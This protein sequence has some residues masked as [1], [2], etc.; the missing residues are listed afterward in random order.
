M[1]I[2]WRLESHPLEDV[3]DDEDLEDEEEVVCSPSKRC[4][5]PRRTLDSGSDSEGV[6]VC[7]YYS[8]SPEV[9]NVY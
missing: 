1:P 5:G 2:K 9:L 6:F 7:Y 4:C 8:S 3:G